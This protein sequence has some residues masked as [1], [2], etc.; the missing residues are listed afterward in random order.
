MY[1][2]S[3]F[4]SINCCRFFLSFFQ[5]IIYFSTRVS[6]PFRLER[7]RN[8][9]FFGS[10]PFAFSSPEKQKQK[11]VCRLRA[12]LFPSSTHFAKRYLLV[13]IHLSFIMEIEMEI[14]L[15]YEGRYWQIWSAINRLDPSCC[16]MFHLNCFDTHSRTESES[17]SSG[18]QDEILPKVI[19]LSLFRTFSVEGS[20]YHPHFPSL[21]LL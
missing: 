14:I 12:R 7:I 4:L 8:F 1:W 18:V 9:V 17:K 5:Q 3:Y 16:F 19:K 11:S 2:Q 20:L 6:V 21:P 13:S 10:S 15:C